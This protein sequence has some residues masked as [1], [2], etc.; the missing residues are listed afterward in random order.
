[1]LTG[2][3]VFLILVV[4]LRSV[5]FTASVFWLGVSGRRPSLHY[6]KDSQLCP[7]IA[8]SCSTLT[9]K[10]VFPSSYLLSFIIISSYV[11]DCRYKPPLVWGASGH[12]QTAFNVLIGHVFVP[13]P[14][15]Q[16]RSLL[17]PDGSSVTYD[18]FQPQDPPPSSLFFL[19]CP[20]I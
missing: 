20:G 10:Y 1:M 14:R 8:R 6:R 11:S 19:L 18:F 2:S 4:F 15:G 3:A 9:E 13:W 7:G 12:V 16:R 17:T 5:Y